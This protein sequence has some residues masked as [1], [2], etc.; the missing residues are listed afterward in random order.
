[1]SNEVLNDNDILDAFKKTGTAKGV[2]SSLNIPYQIVLTT[3]KRNN[4]TLQ[5][6][7]PKKNILG[8]SKDEK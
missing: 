2:A 7:R 6:G 4:V 3:L 5:R 8:Q 1:M